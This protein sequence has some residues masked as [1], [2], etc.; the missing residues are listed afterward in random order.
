MWLE[1]SVYFIHLEINAGTRPGL[2]LG[3]VMVKLN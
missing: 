1:S 3:I 2:S